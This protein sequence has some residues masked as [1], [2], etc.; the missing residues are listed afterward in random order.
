KMT[1]LPAQTFNL[2]DR[3]LV[4]E[5]FAADLVLFDEA[6]V[7]DLATFEQPHQYPSGFSLVVV[8]GRVVFEGGAMTGERPGAALRRG[9]EASSG[10]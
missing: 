9:Q 3:G 5:G 1:S 2:R 7:K 10:R 4:R 8:N 6:S